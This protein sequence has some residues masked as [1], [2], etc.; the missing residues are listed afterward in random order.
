MEVGAAPPD[1]EVVEVATGGL[2]VMVVFPPV[3]FVE[4]TGVVHPSTLKSTHEVL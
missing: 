3:E 1:E 2:V 4:V